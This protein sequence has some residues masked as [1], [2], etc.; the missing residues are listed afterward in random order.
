MRKVLIGF[1]CLCAATVQA[2]DAKYKRGDQVRVQSA[3]GEPA[4]P[5]LQRIVAIPGDHV[6]VEKTTL[7]VNDRVVEGLSP[8]LVT[9]IAQW[10][11]QVVPAGHYVVMGEDRHDDS[12]V[13]SGSLIPAKRI[14]G[15]AA[16]PPSR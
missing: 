16:P 4:S 5:P 2:Q 6:R 12:T 13:R 15:P 8:Q 3:T 7:Y 10:E 1:V 14:I 11:P 9:T